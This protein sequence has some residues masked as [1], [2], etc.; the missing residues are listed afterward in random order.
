MGMA[1]EDQFDPLMLDHAGQS[2]GVGQAFAPLDTARCGRVVD[3]HSPKQAGFAGLPEQ[4]RQPFE[5]RLPYAPNGQ[6]R[7]RGE[8]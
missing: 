6:K 4:R 3:K 8:D 7:C 1:V 2:V 5:L